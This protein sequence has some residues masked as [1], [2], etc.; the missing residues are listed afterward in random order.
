M[1]NALVVLL[2]ATAALAFAVAPARA[3]A[4]DGNW[5]FTDG[6]RI[7]ING[8]DVVIPNGTRMRGNYDRHHFSYTPAGGAPVNMTLQGEFAVTVREGDGPTQ[9][10]RRCQPAVS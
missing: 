6:R 5:C 3:D 8:P 9:I 10:W 4:I 2:A 7:T 1:R